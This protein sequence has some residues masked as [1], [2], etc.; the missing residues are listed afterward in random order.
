M[1]DNPVQIIV[2]AFNDEKTAKAA[3]KELK[4]AQIR[5]LSRQ[6][7]IKRCVFFEYPDCARAFVYLVLLEQTE[8]VYIKFFVSDC[9]RKARHIPW[10][11]C[12]SE[13][14]GGDGEPGC[15]GNRA[16]IDFD[17]V[18]HLLRLADR[19]Q[20]PGIDVRVWLFRPYPEP[21]HRIQ[22]RVMAARG[23]GGTAVI[24]VLVIPDLGDILGIR[25]ID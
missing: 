9:S 4:K 22:L 13:L 25:G 21:G 14:V 15:L 1:S 8:I 2:A 7:Y 20:F 18:R 19:D 17:D 6:V 16:E 12:D 24:V 11:S 10:Y 23:V 5:A 3:L